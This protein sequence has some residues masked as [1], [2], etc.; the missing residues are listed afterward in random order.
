MKF[1]TK[2]LHT[3]NEIDPA[4]G[5][6]SIPVYH[7]STFKQVSTDEFGP[8]DYARSGNPTRDALEAVIACLEGGVRGFAFASGMAAISSVFL[9]F[10]PGDHL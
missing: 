2:I 5:A 3:G 10:S 9:M 7:A 1:S 4:T 6:V 8:Y